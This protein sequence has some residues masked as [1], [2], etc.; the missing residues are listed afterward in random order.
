MTPR[1]A[2]LPRDERRRALVDAALPL[3]R[4]RGSDV[5][6]RQIAEAAGVAEGTIFRV[7]PTKEALVEEAI[8]CAFDPAPVLAALT[9]IDAGLPLEQR[10]R[11]AVE[12]IQEHLVSVFSLVG[13]LRWSGTGSHGSRSHPRSEHRRASAALD[14][15][16]AAVVGE[17]PGLRLP[18]D[19]VARML[20]LLTF[21]GT[22]PLVSDRPLDAEQIVSLVLDGCR[23]HAAQPVGGGPC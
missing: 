2:P 1:A 18:A 7:F 10:L 8:S 17:A 12:L 6:T 21:A 11:R 9:A 23:V 15:A 4:E 16:L 22:H 5:S 20:R 19:E 3:L 14:E 13:A